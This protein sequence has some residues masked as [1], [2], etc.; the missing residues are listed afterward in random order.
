MN[1]VDG[2]PAMRVVGVALE[3][4]TAGSVE[5]MID[6]SP[7]KLYASLTDVMSV[8]DRSDECRSASWLPGARGPGQVGSRFRGHNRAGLVR[9]SR[10]C[11]ILVADPDRQFTFRTVPE[12]FDLS[13]ADSTTWRY[14]LTP[15]EG[16]TLVRH[17]YEITRLP[18]GP[19]KPLYA[20]L[21]PH[22]RDMRPAMSVTL[23]RL[24]ANLGGLGSKG[25]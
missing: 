13:R 6:A 22:H 11:E 9:W 24:A 10:V 25:Q 23:Q 19:F 2:R 21:F 8:G 12:R 15:T 5:L 20:V 17:S 1:G 16:G 18:R 3:W 14:E 4:R 7:E